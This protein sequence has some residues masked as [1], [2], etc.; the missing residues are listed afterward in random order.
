MSK[1]TPETRRKIGRG[2]RLVHAGRDP[3]ESRTIPKRLW[4]D[5]AYAFE[6]AVLG[7]LWS[8]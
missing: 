2:T 6:A 5:L 7:K 3:E 4:E 1:L 8:V